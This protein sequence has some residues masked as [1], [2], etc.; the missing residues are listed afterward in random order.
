MQSIKN[1][2]F[3]IGISLFWFGFHAVDL[4]SN[5]IKIENHVNNFLKESKINTKLMLEETTIGGKTWSLL[6]VYRI[7]LT[8][9]IVGYATTIISLYDFKR[10]KK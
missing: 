7:G 9:L 6:S 1:V 10:C 4:A 5:E 3:V 8:L 2:L